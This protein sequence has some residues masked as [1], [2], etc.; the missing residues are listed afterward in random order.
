MRFI[1]GLRISCIGL[2]V[3]GQRTALTVITVSNDTF[4]FKRYLITRRDRFTKY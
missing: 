1:S 4:R 2:P 3:V